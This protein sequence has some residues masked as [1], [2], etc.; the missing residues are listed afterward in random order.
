MYGGRRTH[1]VSEFNTTDSRKLRQRRGSIFVE[2]LLLVTIVGI[3]VIVGLATVRD[4][5]SNELNDLAN[6]INAINGP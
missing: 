4:A 6:A 5:L 1:A 3:G 2:Y